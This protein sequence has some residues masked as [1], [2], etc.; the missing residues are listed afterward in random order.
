MTDPATTQPSGDASAAPAPVA[1]AQPAA[2][3]PDVESIVSERL[4]AAQAA[5]EAKVNERI[6]GFQRVISEKDEAIR[7]LQRSSMSDE[8]RQQ[9]QIEEE[10]QERQAF[11]TERWLF[12]K[13]KEN[14]SAAELFEKVLSIEDPDEQFAVFADIASRLQPAAPTP[15]PTPAPEP[16]DQV[17]DID[18]N[19]PRGGSVPAGT[20]VT[21]D[22][23]VLDKEFRKSFLQNMPFWP[24]ADGR[25]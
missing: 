8:D 10:E 20:P 1:D 6:T 15:A 5:W 21:A 18:P 25:G 24:G 11:E 19:N 13:A 2:T 14:P 23:Q 22:G 7:N 9:L 17:P 16:S 3:A 12:Q 4:A